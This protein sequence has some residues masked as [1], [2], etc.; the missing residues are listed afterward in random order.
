M[1]LGSFLRCAWLLAAGVLM[2][3]APSFAQSAPKETTGGDYRAKAEQYA[4]AH[5]AFDAETSAYW[6]AIAEKRRVRNVKRRNNEQIQLDD[7]VLTQPPVYK[8]PPRPVDPA[9]PGRESPEPRKPDIPVIADFLKAAAEQFRFVPE[10]PDSEIA[11]KRAYAKAASAAGLS[12]DQIVRIYAFETG[13]NGTYDAQAGLTPPRPGA[14]AISPAIG[15]NQLLSTNSIGLMAEHGDKL[16]NALRQKAKALTG[17]PK[18]TMEHK[19]EALRRMV[20]FSRTVPNVWNEHDILAKTMAGGL[21][22]HAAVLDR[23]I[24]PLLQTQKLLNS[25]LFARSKGYKSPLTAAELEMMNFTGDGNGLDMVLMPASL[26]QQV[27]TANFFQQTGYDRNPIARRTGVV[28]A[29]FAAIETKMDQASQ[30]QGAKD[31][32]AAF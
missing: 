32:A 26:R 22:I 9:S 10:R 11:F 17:D 29:L 15:Y 12:R 16:I 20:A 5:R 3:A 14:R 8:G 21:G 6:K 19:I 2:A 31:L 28:A 24:G 27:P 13:G 7:Y 25:V 1:R 30:S 18:S 23:D 4:L